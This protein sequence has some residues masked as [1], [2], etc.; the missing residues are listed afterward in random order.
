MLSNYLILCRPLLLLPS[1]FSSIRSFLSIKWPK[2]WS[3]SFSISPSN[4]YSELI[5]FRICWFDLFAVQG[6]LKS[7]LQ[8]H[9]SKALIVQHSAF[10]MV[11][12]SYPYMTNRKTTALTLWTFKVISLLFNKLSRFVMTFFPRSKCFLISWL[13]S[14]TTVILQLNKIKSVTVYTFSSSI[15]QEVMGLDGMILVS[16]MLSFK[17]AFHSP[18]S[19][20]TRVSSTS[21]EFIFTFCQ[22]YQ[23]HI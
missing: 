23:L 16:L 14:P 10:F 1:I 5:S 9:N 12:F 8:H 13:Q 21:E 15:C 22:E 19:L 20:S 6:T 11:Q 2:Y 7:L 18:F 3:F 4:A 17:P